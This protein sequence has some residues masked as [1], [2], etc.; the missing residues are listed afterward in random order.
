VSRNTT[1][2]PTP[3]VPGSNCTEFSA[4][5]DTGH[6]FVTWP[7]ESKREAVLE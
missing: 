6:G 5:F 2:C 7:S 3:E 4:I 1:T